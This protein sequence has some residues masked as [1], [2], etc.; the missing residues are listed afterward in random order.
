MA[1][2]HKLTK[3]GQTI[4]PATTT[5]AV[6]HPTSRKNLTEELSKLENYNGLDSP[7]WGVAVQEDFSK[8]GMFL[9]NG[10]FSG[11]NHY[12]T[13]LYSLKSFKKGVASIQEYG[14]G[15]YSIGI[16]D[17]NFKMIKP[18]MRVN[19]MDPKN[20]LYS[21]I[22]NDSEYYLFATSRINTGGKGPELYTE[23]S[24][25]NKIQEITKSIELIKPLNSSLIVSKE[26][27]LS[28]K[29]SLDGYFTMDNKFLT[30]QYTTEF[31][32]LE[33]CNYILKGIDYG[34]ALVTYGYSKAMSSSVEDILLKFPMNSPTQEPITFRLNKDDH[35]KNAKFIFVTKR[36]NYEKDLFRLSDT[37]IS[38]MLFEADFTKMTESISYAGYI[39]HEEWLENNS[40]TTYYYPLDKS[41]DYKIIGE[42]YGSGIP[43][44]GFATNTNKEKDSIIKFI[45]MNAGSGVVPFDVVIKKEDIPLEA[46]YIFVVSRNSNPKYLYEGLKKFIPELN[47]EKINLLETLLPSGTFRAR[48]IEYTDKVLGK[49]YTDNNVNR[50]FNLLQV[51]RKYNTTHD[52]MVCLG[53]NGPNGM[54][55]IR[56]WRLLSNQNRTLSKFP[57]D[58]SFT[59]M[60]ETIGPWKIKS[61][62]N[63]VGD[64]GQDFVGGFH[65]LIN[66]DTDSNYP[67]A[68]NLGYIFYAD[69]KELSV[70]EEVFCNSITAISSVNICSS[71]TFDKQTNTAREVLNY[72]DTYQMQGDKI[73]VFAKFKALE[74]ITI[75]LHYGLQTAV[76]NPIIGYLTDN[77][78]IETNTSIDYDKKEITQ[79]PYLVY[80]KKNDGNT[81]YCKMYDQGAM[82]GNRANGVKA[83]QMSYGA[84][85]T[86]TY[87]Y[88]Y[89]NG[90]I[91]NLKKGDSNYYTGWFCISDKDFAIVD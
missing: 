26:T 8:V 51:I 15:Y 14:S 63:A 28:S 13:K 10:E 33:D 6:V 29:K 57:Q 46:N 54:F 24:G 75:N 25:V 79:I 36:K 78:I 61:V 65:A 91:G 39:L 9:L 38:D 86:K 90:K 70:G 32:P 76:F 73:Y 12:E 83:F 20:V 27:K 41:L 50:T 80:A 19:S 22:S 58:T 48:V 44:Y 85:N 74:D 84:G 4:Y 37:Y 66:P 30:G 3:D 11:N 40:Y 42:E 34:T 52:I 60:S 72:Q 88:V 59:E 35:P 77:G 45:N 87:H 17:S 7:H 16:S 23:S 68:K 31:Y 67:S 53:L 89:G 49:E 64:S 71:N 1:K 43:S 62:S 56:G 47:K 69:N 21:F 82:T 55:G 18:I 5:D 81:L 2:I